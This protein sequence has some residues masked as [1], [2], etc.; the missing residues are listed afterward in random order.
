MKHDTVN[1]DMLIYSICRVEF[2]ITTFY[3][4]T[5]SKRQNKQT[6]KQTYHVSHTQNNL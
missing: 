4:T 2:M 3:T 5:P 1:T 6:K